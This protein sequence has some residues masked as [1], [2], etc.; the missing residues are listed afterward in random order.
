M[1]PDDIKITP[2][3]N[4]DGLINWL[5]QPG[6]LRIRPQK[7]MRVRSSQRIKFC[8]TRTVPAAETKSMG[9]QANALVP[10]FLLAT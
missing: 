8:G 9:L 5:R 6:Q 3:P 1:Y 10:C 7:S 2:A 4:T